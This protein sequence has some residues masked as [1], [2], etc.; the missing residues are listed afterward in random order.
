MTAFTRGGACGPRRGAVVLLLLVSGFPFFHG[1]RDSRK[2]LPG[3]GKTRTQLAARRDSA[4]QYSGEREALSSEFLK[5]G[6]PGVAWKFRKNSSRVSFSCRHW[7]H[8]L[9]LPST[10]LEGLQSRRC[11]CTDSSCFRNSCRST[12][13]TN[14]IT[15]SSAGRSGGNQTGT[16]PQALV[17]YQEWLVFT[18]AEAVVGTGKK[19]AQITKEGA[20]HP[21][22]HIEYNPDKDTDEPFVTPVSSGHPL[23]LTKTDLDGI[24]RLAPPENSERIEEESVNERAAVKGDALQETRDAHANLDVNRTA[25]GEQRRIAVFSSSS[26]RTVHIR[27]VA[28]HDGSGGTTVTVT[29]EIRNTQTGEVDA[30]F[31]DNVYFTELFKEDGA[32]RVTPAEL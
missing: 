17:N 22:P 7:L 14:S 13:E 19:R 24:R 30:S 25:L 11:N 29:A 8:G 28:V 2:D 20:E 4:G 3:H 15:S 27:D 32:G 5:V 16:A 1:G 18:A 26:S 23:G 21:D 9:S 12:G 6:V 31:D 10:G